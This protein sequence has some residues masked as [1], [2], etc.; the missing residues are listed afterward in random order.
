ME[1]RQITGRLQA[2]VKH[3][4]HEENEN[5]KVLMREIVNERRRATANGKIDVLFT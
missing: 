2:K 3:K 4:T 5:I 1:T